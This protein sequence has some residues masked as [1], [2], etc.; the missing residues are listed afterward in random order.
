[1]RILKLALISAVV[2]FVILI[3]LFALF[4]SQ[5]SVSRIQSIHTSKETAAKAVA[6]LDTWSSW[7][8]FVS[9][10]FLNHISISVPPSGMGAWLR[11][12]QLTVRI[13]RIHEDS[14]FSVWNT[15][16]G[17][18]FQATFNFVSQDSANVFIQWNYQFH[19]AW[20]PWEKLGAMFYEKQLGPVMEK[21]L[22]DL[23]SYLEK[24]P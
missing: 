9:D 19:V 1:M 3:F 14:V 6:N 13:N 20:Y 11:S 12:D 17:K 22:V 16:N 8:H 21:S 4:P 15:Q 18:T 10:S 23:K 7:N 2:F 5:I 24:N